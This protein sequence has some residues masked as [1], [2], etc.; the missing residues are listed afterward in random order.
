[1]QIVHHCPASYGPVELRLEAA[2]SSLGSKVMADPVQI[3]INWDKH[4]CYYDYDFIFLNTQFTMF[5]DALC[6]VQCCPTEC[7][8]DEGGPDDPT[9][10]DFDKTVNSVTRK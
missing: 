5:R 8:R 9:Y 6:F 1:M 4:T 7:M 3:Q 2:Q 10:K